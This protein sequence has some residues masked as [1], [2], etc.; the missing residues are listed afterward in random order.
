MVNIQINNVNGK[1]VKNLI[2]K[3]QPTGG[4]SIHWDG[5]DDSGVK[6]ASGIYVYRLRTADCLQ[7]RKMILIR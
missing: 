6:V 3:F 7:T 5:K 1:L 4:Y 2:D